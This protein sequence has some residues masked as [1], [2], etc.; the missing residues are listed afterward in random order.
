MMRPPDRESSTRYFPLT[1]IA[2]FMSNDPVID[3]LLDSDPSISWQVM[4]DLTRT[5]AEIVAVE[6]ARVASE[7][8][9]PLLLDQQRPDGQW[10]DG[11]ATPPPKGAGAV[12]A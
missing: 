6:R 9:G 11:V 8:W 3:W 1:A 10:G 4:R 12:P 7:G 2:A 5:P